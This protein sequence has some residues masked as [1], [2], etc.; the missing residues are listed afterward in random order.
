MRRMMRPRLLLPAALLLTACHS[1]IP[2]PDVLLITVDPLRADRL[3]CYGY[4]RATSPH[5][6]RLASRGV[7]FQRA[8]TTLP[9]TT[10]SVASIMTGR[11]PKAH[12]ARGLFSSLS[13]A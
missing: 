9:R 1:S 3:G 10:Q 7:L 13:P 4:A 2:R 6:D 11:Y 12:G 8:F 5:I